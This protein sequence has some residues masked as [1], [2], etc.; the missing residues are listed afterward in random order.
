MTAHSKTG[1]K[2]IIR[3][4]KLHCNSRVP[5]WDISSAAL[6]TNR[7]HVYHNMK[8]NAT[9]VKLEAVFTTMTAHVR[10]P[11]RLLRGKQGHF[12]MSLKHLHLF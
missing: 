5:Y 10:V 11:V 2:V 9:W 4:G 6:N 12:K 3:V 1:L 8:H 7:S